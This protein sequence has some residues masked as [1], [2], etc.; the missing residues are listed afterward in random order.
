MKF[1]LGNG[2]WAEVPCVLT[3]EDMLVEV[4]NEEDV[5]KPHT[6]DNTCNCA[7]CSSELGKQMREILDY[8]DQD[9]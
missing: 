8:L 9:D 7:F 2:E 3:K 5:Y 4:V 1:P 6:A